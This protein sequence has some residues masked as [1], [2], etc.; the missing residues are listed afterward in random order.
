[1]K[2][3]EPIIHPVVFVP[4]GYGCKLPKSL[5][6]FTDAVKV[7]FLFLYIFGLPVILYQLHTNLQRTKHR[8][9]MLN[10]NKMDLLM[11]E[12]SFVKRKQ[13]GFA[14]EKYLIKEKMRAE[15][16]D[17]AR[18]LSPDESDISIQ[19]ESIRMEME[20]GDNWLHILF[21]V[22][23]WLKQN[24]N[25]FI[26]R[27]CVCESCSD[28][29]FENI[30]R[31]NVISAAHYSTEGNAKR[32]R[33]TYTRWGQ[34]ACSGNNNLTNMV[35]TIYQGVMATT[36]NLRGSSGANYLCLPNQPTYDSRISFPVNNM[37]PYLY[38]SLIDMRGYEDLELTNIDTLGFYLAPCS[39]CELSVSKIVMMPGLSMCPTSW[40][41]VYNGNMMAQRA[42]KK[43][44]QY[45]CVD[46]VIDL[47]TSDRVK[48]FTRVFSSLNF[49]ETECRGLP[50]MLSGYT[51]YNEIPCVMCSKF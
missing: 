18:S 49:V 40:K 30:E 42:G 31:K 48:R 3:D 6:R 17:A 27:R 20:I 8:I 10:D 2:P 32:Y 26:D 44:T 14:E 29:S 47:K 36:S 21:E 7:A 5:K 1:M 34:N 24:P 13:S 25:F 33:K 50:C 39:V 43:R 28:C 22:E 35:A 19:L 41:L 46:S 12:V 11:S 9:H 51:R 16:K 23:K 38:S 15:Y 37:S 45:M 4:E